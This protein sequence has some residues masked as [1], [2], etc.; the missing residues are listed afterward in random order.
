MPTILSG[1]SAV[2]TVAEQQTVSL[3]N[4]VTAKARVEVVTG[5]RA[6]RVVA[7]NHHGR[8][9][10][11]PFAAGTIV[12]G[13]T[14]G[15]VTYELSG[16]WNFDGPPQSLTP[17][18]N[19]QVLAGPNPSALAVLGDSYFANAHNYSG[20]V[21]W[22]VNAN[23]PVGALNA[24]LGG[25][26][27]LVY[28][29]AVS[30][31]TSAAWVANQLAG[32]INS[33][34]YTVWVGFPTNDPVGALTFAQ[35]VANLSAIYTALRD[36]GKS[37]IV[38]TA[39]NNAAW[40]GAQRSLA[41]QVSDWIT[42]RAAEN[43]WPVWDQLSAMSDPATGKGS[44]SLFLSESGAYVHPNAAG[45]LFTAA[46]SYANF[47]ARFPPRP[48]VAANGPNQAFYNT[49]LTGDTAGVPDGW[50]AY[51]NGTPT[52][53]SRAKVARTDG[54]QELVRLTATSDAAGSRWGISTNAISLTGAWSAAAKVLGQRCK[55]S[56]GDHWVCTTAGTSS[57]S[58]PAAMAAASNLGDTVT[59]SGGVVWTRY[60][61]IVPGTTKLTIR[62]EHDIT[63][64]SLGDLGAQLVVICNFSSGTPNGVRANNQGSTTDPEQRWTFT[65]SRR[66]VLQT[67]YQV[68]VPTGTTAMQLFMFM[69][70]SAA[71]TI[72][73]LDLYGVEARLD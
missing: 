4:A 32:V 26:F 50:A 6:G 53:T 63:T 27:D 46:Q 34:A 64:V 31:S 51:S 7:D 3:S 21:L 16:S 17:L 59:D 35:T 66:P 44:T 1:Q 18:Q 23:S 55:G 29:G 56:Y 12:I 13:A 71:D 69:Q 41:L 25:A 8:A 39:G 47:A 57:G 30:G 45:V 37:I 54:I 72:A 42:A 68:V 48:V 11:G 36:A 15:N 61:T 22:A 65:H 2:I 40:T 28:D 60:K 9:S 5:P 38:N 70:W 62:V 19:A 52:T 67:P 20:T 43:S 73:T 24:V 33:S 10:Y 49:A 58:E 14:S